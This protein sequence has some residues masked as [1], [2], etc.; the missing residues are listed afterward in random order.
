MA[1]DETNTEQG[2]KLR[3]KGKKLGRRDSGLRTQNFGLLHAVSLILG[4]TCD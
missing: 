2:I 1:Q 4:G 3:P